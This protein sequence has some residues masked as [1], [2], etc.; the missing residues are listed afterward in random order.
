[1]CA[2]SGFYNYDSDK[3]HTTKEK[4][5]IILN[6]MIKKL[7]HRGPDESGIFID[8][9]CNFAHTRLSIIDLKNG[10][11]PMN[12][13]TKDGLFSIVYNGEI[14][15]MPSLRNELIKS[16]V[17]LNTSSDTEVILKGFMNEGYSFFEKLNGIFS[18][19]IWESKKEKLTL[20]RDRLG[21][22]PLFYTIFDN[23]II[24]SSEI[25]GLF[26]YPNF[27]PKIDKSG[28]CE[29]F[30]LGP[31]KSYG[32]GVFK[33][34]FEVLPGEFIE[35]SKDGLKHSKYWELIAKHHED[36]YKTTV[37]K[38]R[39]L[40]EDA[41]SLQILS[42]VPICSFLSGGIDSSLITA[43]ASK[44]LKERNLELNTFSFDF[45]NND[46]FFKSNSFQP[47]LDRPYVDKMVEYLNTNHRYLF[48]NNKNLYD[49][50]FDAVI[51]RDLPCMADVESSILY[52]CSEVVKYNKVALTGECADEIFG[53][54]P[55]F[56]DEVALKRDNFPWSYD[57]A[58]RERL[59]KDEWISLLNLGSYS[60]DA[61]HKTVLETPKLS[62]ET[63]IE[64]RRREL[65]YL[66]L[67]WF[68]TTLLDR[69]DRT[70]MYSSLEARVPFADHRIVEYLY[71]VPWEYKCKDGVVKGLLRDASKPYLPSE[72]LMR[73][74]SPYPKTYDPSYE[75][76]L[77]EKLLELL[78]DENAPITR[79]L[80]KEKVLSFLN[81][82]SDYGKPFYGQLMAGPQLLAF[83]L[84]VN[85]FFS[86]YNVEI[87]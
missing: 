3:S 75:K 49:K 86:Y 68:M 61:Y 35:I 16:N 53:G 36:N 20:V 72:I 37:E 46:K 56:S 9:G 17:E 73:R 82:E 26:V 39:Y 50:L 23:T 44:K 5:K 2:I 55:W 15:N 79:F 45:I 27:T 66:N 47:S 4:A 8:K 78:K 33:D 7:T 64:A 11:Q 32:K 74:K 24:F 69:M 6:E 85:F 58:P 38:T 31:A 76:L 18:F 67:R 71:N 65:S 19:A 34:V 63:E 25:K 59:L 48:C 54:Y 28:L 22:K 40:I 62:G 52:F 83:M 81:S 10:K 60:Y 29:I 51:A 30:G 13:T 1:M 77:G 42:D 70:S 14:Y 43:I 21:V 41:V 57:M 84:Q 12:F 87:V 80:D